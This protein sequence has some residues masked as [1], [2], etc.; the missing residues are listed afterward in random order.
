M[1]ITLRSIY[2][3]LL[4]L[5]YQLSPEA[6]NLIKESENPEYLVSE[7]IKRLESMENKPIIIE[8][9]HIE[10]LI[11]KKISSPISLEQKK[12]K[13]LPSIKILRSGG[14]YSVESSPEA[15]RSYF[16]DRFNK[17]K[18]ILNSRADVRAY[19]SNNKK[20]KII[21]IVASKKETKDK[22]A[23]ELENEKGITKILFKDK[24]LKKKASRIMLDEVIC[25]FG[26]IIENIGVIG[27]D[28]IWPDITPRIRQNIKREG[29]IVFTSDI[30]IGSKFFM[31]QQFESFIKWLRGENDE[32]EIASKVKYLIIA[33]DIVDGIGIY[34]NQEEELI[35]KDIY[36]QYEEAAYYLSMIPENIKI[37]IIPGNHDACRQT[38][39]TPP[40]YKDIGAPL[41][42]LKNVVMLGDPSFIEI[43]N[44]V[45][46]ITHGRSLDDV[47]PVI[48]NCTFK[49]PQKAMI[50]LLKSRHIAPIYGEKTPIA[51]EP[52]D[53]L[54]IDIIPDIFHAGHVHVWG[55]SE[56]QGTFVINSGTWQ[57]QTKYQ[58]SMGIEPAPGIVPVIDL[59]NFKITTLNFL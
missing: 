24:E 52:E 3:T 21:G 10:P 4:N 57:K 43:E 36:K 18:S 45:F 37:I 22:I 32:K 11:T 58:Q 41:Y 48:P 46:L 29:C 42:S 13:C 39:P 8:R 25:V 19:N 27:E 33:G 34:P 7:L 38:L 47:I 26:T 30:H 23:I 2:S 35:I 9:T 50:E 28:I 55:I 12:E 1:E 14:K 20:V 56:Y 51:P 53:I 17:L 5:G 59:S 49:E 54:V 6:F 40:I 44:L 16:L 15:F 31:R